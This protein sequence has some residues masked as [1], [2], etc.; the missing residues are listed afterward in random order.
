MNND[1]L[2]LV[3]VAIVSIGHPGER[4]LRSFRLRLFISIRTMKDV[5]NVSKIVDSCQ[6]NYKIWKTRNPH[7]EKMLSRI[8]VHAS[9]SNDNQSEV[10]HRANM[11][12][13]MQY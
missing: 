12:E 11:N 10:I 3:H 13:P 7:L 2:L 9:G 5:C 4:S 1:A 8:D 6:R